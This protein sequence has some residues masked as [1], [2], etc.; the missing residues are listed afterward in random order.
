MVLVR[1]WLDRCCEWHAG[2]CVPLVFK[3]QF[4]LRLIDVENECIVM[5]TES[6][7]YVALSYTWGSPEQREKEGGLGVFLT[8]ATYQ[9]FSEPGGLAKI[10][11]RMP[12]SISDSMLFCRMLGVQYLWVDALCIRQDSKADK[13]VQLPNMHFV[14]GAAF[15]TIVAAA[16][17]TSWAGLPGVRPHSR[18]T[19]QCHTSVDGCELITLARPFITMI[20]KSAWNTRAWT[21]EEKILSARLLFFTE[22]QSFFHCNEAIWYEDAMMD[23]QDPPFQ[24]D[25]RQFEDLKDG[26]NLRMLKTLQ[27]NGIWSQ[28]QHA[29]TGYTARTLTDP[30]DCLNAFL[31]IAALLRPS[32]DKDFIWGLPEDPF[33]YALAWLWRA[34]PRP[35]A[36]SV[37]A[38]SWSWASWLDSQRPGTN[39][40]VGTWPGSAGQARRVV[41]FF[42]HDARTHKLTYMDSSI[43]PVSKVALDDLVLPSPTLTKV[44]SREHRPNPAH[45]FLPCTDIVP[46][47]SH[48]LIFWARTALLT[49]DYHRYDGWNQ[50]W[51]SWFDGS[52]IP[53][54][55]APKGWRK[56][57]RHQDLTWPYQRSVGDKM[58][59]YR[60]RNARGRPIG[61][62]EL[63]P[64]WRNNNPKQLQFVAFL[65]YTE[66]NGVLTMA[67]ERKDKL[68]FRIQ[69][70]YTIFA[71]KDWLETRPD[72]QRFILC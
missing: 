29:V 6:V 66:P 48:R 17:E 26:N 34:E 21:Y 28:Y 2:A 32:F 59:S 46:P 52:R 56:T 61:T 27:G 49:V 60:I 72:W 4:P 10:N 24:I 1:S 23:V 68:S 7:K 44:Q 71:E 11:E 47:I 57:A 35:H 20:K 63:E 43:P 70:A 55:E 51:A 41:L 31:G 53:K 14:Y 38:P 62:I 8:E 15:L 22:Y 64:Q 19:P 12:T 50:R 25:Q 69:R 3:G 45:E 37:R 54:G 67:V 33:D 16:G 65:G 36:R 40:G 13:K 5:A 39:A 18:N 9:L 30:S 42:R 58:S